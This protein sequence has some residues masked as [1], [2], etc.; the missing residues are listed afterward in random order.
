[1]KK[2][3]IATV[4]YDGKTILSIK[5]T[6]QNNVNG[7]LMVDKSLVD[8]AI[9]S[10]K[11]LR[12]TYSTGFAG[13]LNCGIYNF[14]PSINIS[15]DTKGNYAIQGTF[16]G[17]PSTGTPSVSIVSS[18]TI[19][20]AYNVEELN[21]DSYQVG[22]TAGEMVG[23]IPLTVSGEVSIIP[24]KD[25]GVPYFGGTAAIGLGTPGSEVHVEWGSTTTWTEGNIVDDIS[26]T[27]DKITSIFK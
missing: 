9:K 7:R 2:T 14:S 12:G 18:S 11:G 23:T 5:S 4:K 3:K 1:M 8:N 10:A 15:I 6:P 16:V 19:T 25:G 27:I 24:K 13:T 21:G 26:N 17:G 22:G 20:N